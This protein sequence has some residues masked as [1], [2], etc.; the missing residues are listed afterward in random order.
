MTQCNCNQGRLPCS[1]DKHGTIERSTSITL[2]VSA[3]LIACLYLA[4]HYLI[5]G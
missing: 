5:G 2:V 3:L 1:C 4:A